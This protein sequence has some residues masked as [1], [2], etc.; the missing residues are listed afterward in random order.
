MPSSTTSQFQCTTNLILIQ[1]LVFQIQP[2]KTVASNYN[3]SDVEVLNGQLQDDTGIAEFAL[4]RKLANTS[5]KKGD[6]IILHQVAKKTAPFYPGIDIKVASGR[7]TTI[8]VRN[9]RLYHTE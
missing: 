7:Y 5:L 6:T 1:K 3:N 9:S 2:V 4:W 8:E